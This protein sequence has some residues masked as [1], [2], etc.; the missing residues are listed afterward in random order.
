MQ[1][2]VR[3]TVAYECVLDSSNTSPDVIEES[4]KSPATMQLVRTSQ[5]ILILESNATRLLKLGD[6]LSDIDIPEGGKHN[7]SYVSDT[8]EVLSA[9]VEKF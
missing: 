6:I 8:F 7:S 3:Y 1:I 4:I 2:R 9:K 5:P